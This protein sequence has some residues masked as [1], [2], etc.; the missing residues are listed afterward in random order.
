MSGSE[1]FTT[2]SETFDALS[3]NPSKAKW[4]PL[5]IGVSTH[6]VLE[7][8]KFKN[9]GADLVWGKPP[10]TMSQS[11]GYELV[12]ALTEKRGRHICRER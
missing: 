2:I 10:P 3:S 11:L 9:H 6:P 5:L 8:A 1:L 12:A 4:R 7:E